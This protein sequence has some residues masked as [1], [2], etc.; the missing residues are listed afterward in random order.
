MLGAI[1]TV[2]P[3]P[4]L[5]GKAEGV[6]GEGGGEWSGLRPN[7]KHRRNAVAG[8]RSAESTAAGPSAR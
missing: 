2:N 5:N 6:A 3:G 1:R 7:R 4:F 8:R